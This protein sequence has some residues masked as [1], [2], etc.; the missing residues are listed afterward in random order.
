MIKI[1]LSVLFCC[2]LA[3]TTAIAGIA[4]TPSRDDIPDRV[5]EG[6][7]TVIDGDTIKIGGQHIHLAGIDALEIHQKCRRDGIEWHCGERAKAWLEHFIAG[8][9]VRCFSVGE[10]N[11]HH[12][13]ANCTNAAGVQLAWAMVHWGFAINDRLYGPNFAPSQR[14][15]IATKKCIWSGEFVEPALWRQSGI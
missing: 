7:A 12:L 9:K 10:K 2:L 11:V 1:Y 3:P 4:L 8:T 6:Q 5:I 13:M 14:V 15:A